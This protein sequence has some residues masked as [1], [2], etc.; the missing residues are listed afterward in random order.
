MLNSRSTGIDVAGIDKY[1]ST[2][3]A[4]HENLEFLSSQNSSGFLEISVQ[5][6]AM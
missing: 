2:T 5:G 3:F 6:S 1:F 4:K